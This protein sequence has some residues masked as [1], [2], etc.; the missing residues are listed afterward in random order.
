M[1][2]ADEFVAVNFRLWKKRPRTLFNHL[3]LGMAILL[4]SVGVYR[5]VTRFK[6]VTEWGSVVFLLVA[7]LYAGVRMAIVRYELRRGY[8]KNTGLHQP[9]TFTF[10]ADTL[11]GN[12]AS[13][14]FEAR[15]NTIRRAVWVK[16]NWL[17]LY[18]TEAACYYVDLRRVQTPDA[19]EQLLALVREAEIAV[20]EV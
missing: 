17:L 5:D 16:P 6:Q 2:T 20:R 10:G 12:S 19:P 11:S 4:L 7:I 15:W 3:L 13:G 9:I 14:H 18:P 8:T 1:M